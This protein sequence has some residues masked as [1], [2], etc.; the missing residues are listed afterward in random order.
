MARFYFTYGTEGQPYC[1]GW[2][3]V[4]A[5]DRSRAEA[6]FR[7][8]HPDKMKGFLNCSSVYNEEL[9]RKTAMAAEGNFGA[10]CHEIIHLSREL[11][12]AESEGS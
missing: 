12:T 2:S 8:Y 11:L 4:E 6:A 1:G 7:A 3:V 10:R 5:P 9:F